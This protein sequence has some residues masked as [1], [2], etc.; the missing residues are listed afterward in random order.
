MN[1]YPTGAET[2]ST[3]HIDVTPSANDSARSA[4]LGARSA[5]HAEA[6]TEAGMTI[7]IVVSETELGASAAI[8]PITQ[9]DHSPI[10]A[11]SVTGAERWSRALANE[12]PAVRGSDSQMRAGAH[13]LT[14]LLVGVIT[15][16]ICRFWPSSLTM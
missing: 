3:A 13:R 6:T 4:P 7:R 5:A 9:I 12:E 16:E 14:A 8:R 11:V 2:E 15:H 1:V 10:A